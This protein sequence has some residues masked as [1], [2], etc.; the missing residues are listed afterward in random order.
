ME[1]NFL[2]LVSDKK[3]ALCSYPVLILVLNLSNPLNT[4]EGVTAIAVLI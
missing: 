2:K 1:A 3:S 4:R